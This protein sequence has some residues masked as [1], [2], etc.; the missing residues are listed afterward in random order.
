VEEVPAYPRGAFDWRPE[1]GILTPAVGALSFKIVMSKEA[2][3]R[4]EARVRRGPSAR[5]AGPFDPA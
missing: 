3:V 4:A 1:G 5:R 2:A